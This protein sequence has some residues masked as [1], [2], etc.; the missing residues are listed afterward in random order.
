VILCDE[1]ASAL[2]VSIQAQVLDLVGGRSAPG[3]CGRPDPAA[4]VSA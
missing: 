4:A 1:P 2:D 3:H